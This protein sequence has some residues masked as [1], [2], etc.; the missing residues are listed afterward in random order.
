MSAFSRE[1]R[2][3]AARAEYRKA[4][5]T[6][7]K[8]TGLQLEDALAEARKELD[9]IEAEYRKAAAGEA[10]LKQ[11]TIY[12]ISAQAVFSAF[13]AVETLAELD[14]LIAAEDPMDAV[15]R[16]R[17]SRGLPRIPGPLEEE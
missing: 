14:Q 4:L 17:E 5:Q 8:A 9:K 16:E 10:Y 12:G 6:R 3:T 1:E 2:K 7:V 15:N 11:G 13:A